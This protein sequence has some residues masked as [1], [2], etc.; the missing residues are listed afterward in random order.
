MH[1]NIIAAQSTDM[2]CIIFF[3]NISNRESKRRLTSIDT[4]VE[5]FA[6]CQTRISGACMY[7][8]TSCAHLQEAV[9]GLGEF[10]NK[11]I[12]FHHPSHPLVSGW[13]IDR[14]NFWKM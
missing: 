4:I 12:I 5:N 13:G 1:T 6:R 8:W 10:G 3:L 7:H 11:A 14:K 9:H 2:Q